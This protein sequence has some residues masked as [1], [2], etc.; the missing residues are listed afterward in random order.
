MSKRRILLQTNPPWLK[1]GL[2]QNASTLLKY[3]WKTNKYT[4]GHYCS[5]V[6]ELDPNLSL[7]PWKSYGALPSDPR[8]VQELNQDPGK[9]RDAAYGAWNID[10]VVKDFKPDILVG[11]DDAWGFGKSNY[12]D[13]PWWKQI[14]AILH[15][16]I[17]SLPVLEQA[18]EQA[19]NTKHYLTWA[20]FAQKE[21]RRMGPKF[22]HIGQI[23]GAMDT[24]QFSPI[25]AQ[26]KADLRKRFG[27]SPTTTI[28]NYVFRNQ[29]RKS[30]NLI[31]EAFRDFKKENPSADVKL[32]FHTS[33]SERQNGW[34]FKK[35]MGFYGI[36]PRDV[37]FTYVCRNCGQWHVA[38][39]QGEDINCPYCKSEKS[40]ITVNIVH[41]VAPEEM[42]YIYGLADAE[43]SAFTTGGQEL[44][45]CQSMLCGLPLAST[46]YSSGEDFCLCDQVYP[47]SWH[48]YHEAGTNFIKAATEVNDIKKFMFKVWRTPPK[49]MKEWGERSRAWAKDTFSVET[50]GSQ[51]ERLFD[52]MPIINWETVD[53]SPKLKNDQFPFPK[54]EDPDQFITSL[55][56]NILKMDES[57]HGDG[58]RHWLQKIK[59]GMNREDIYKYFISVA[60]SE[61]QK[62]NAPQQDFSTLLDKTTGRKRALLVIRQSLGDCLMITQ[63]LESFHQQYKGYDLYIATEPKYFSVFEGNPFIYKVIPYQDF[64]E[65]EMICIGS[66]QKEGLFSVYMH[67]A[68][69]SQRQL[70]YLSINNIAQEL[71]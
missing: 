26:E 25:T 14:N 22:A 4:L 19:E 38:P 24:E 51:W 48:P 45:N 43:I 59:E 46:N 35:M 62:N 57:P 36:D 68:I 7:T 11:S 58:R 56:V 44:T 20:K 49:Q 37:L 41:G 2:G 6:S 40:M 70:N 32:H 50:I 17:D 30:A 69:Q 34:D 67:P 29:L 52:S 63:L 21:M 54:I 64:M 60:V 16:T 47:L 42:R 27:I 61:N 10:K 33:V 53:L 55:Y 9:A 1:T 3:L 23:Y 31:L 12:I 66:G 28:F 71:R 65:S 15:I 18:F 5:Q 13:K 8:L 39:Y